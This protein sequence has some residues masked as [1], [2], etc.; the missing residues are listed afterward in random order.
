M[1]NMQDKPSSVCGCVRHLC[2]SDK[3]HAKAGRA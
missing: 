3:F 1:G 2:E